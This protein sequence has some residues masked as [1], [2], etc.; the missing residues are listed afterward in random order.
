MQYLFTS[1]NS[2]KKQIWLLAYGIVFI[3]SLLFLLFAI[4][5]NATYWSYIFFG[6]VILFAS[7]AFL[8]KKHKAI[9]FQISIVIIAFGWIKLNYSWLGIVFII[10]LSQAEKFAA[11]ISVDITQN[12]ITIKNV[13]KKN[14]DWHS[15]QNVILKEGLLTLDF[16]NNKLLHIEITNKFSLEQESKFNNFCQSCLKQQ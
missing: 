15:L 4:K 1:T 16:K 11:D 5:G 9:F 14:Y 10:L 8:S 7:L 3:N 13:F 6:L 12:T 2:R